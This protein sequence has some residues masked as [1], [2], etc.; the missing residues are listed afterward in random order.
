M[1]ANI[2]HEAAQVSHEQTVRDV[3][4]AFM[5]E[6]AADQSAIRQVDFVGAEIRLDGCDHAAL[7]RHPPHLL[8][9]AFR[10]R[11]IDEH[12]LGSGD[13]EACVGE[14]QGVCVA[15]LEVDR[16]LRRL[17]AG[18]RLLDEGR[19]LV[20]AGEFAAGLDQARQP[21][22]RKAEAAADIEDRRPHADPG[23]FT[24]KDFSCWSCG[25]ASKASSAAT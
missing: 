2:Q 7:A 22:A 18:L 11:E 17:G 15:H 14:R 19:T 9:C 16:E 24:R 1:Q 3:G 12:P 5:V 23:P 8:Q 21:Q 25:R 4:V 20:D 10:V 6:H 13:L